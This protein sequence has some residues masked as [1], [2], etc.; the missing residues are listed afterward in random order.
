MFQNINR[1]TLIQS[2]RPVI[3]LL[4]NGCDLCHCCSQGC[5]NGAELPG[6]IAGFEM[7]YKAIKNRREHTGS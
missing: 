2:L 1:N 5:Q 4:S 6:H 7:G 3:K